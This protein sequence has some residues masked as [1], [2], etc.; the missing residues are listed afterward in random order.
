MALGC[1]GNNNKIKAMFLADANIFSNN[2]G[3][4]GVKPT[5]DTPGMGG[6]HTLCS[7]PPCF[8]F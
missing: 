1:S 4:L 3:P 8:C 7:I 6:G 2:S 5:V